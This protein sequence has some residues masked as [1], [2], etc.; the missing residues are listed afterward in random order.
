MFSKNKAAVAVE[1]DNEARLLEILHNFDKI[2]YRGQAE[3]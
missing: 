1:Y 2:V 3:S